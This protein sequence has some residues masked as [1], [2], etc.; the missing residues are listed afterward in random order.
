MSTGGGRAAGSI[1]PELCGI[2]L[3]LWRGISGVCSGFGKGAGRFPL[4][5]PEFS[6]ETIIDAGLCLHSGAST[7][8]NANKTRNEF[9]ACKLTC[10]C[11]SENQR[12]IEGDF[13]WGTIEHFQTSPSLL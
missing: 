3:D 13:S 4:N 7:Q 9:D 8:R 1:G 11:H 10:V 12:K 5:T 6:L 2:E